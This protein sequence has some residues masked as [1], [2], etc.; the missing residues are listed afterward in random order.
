MNDKIIR[1]A[2]TV[3]G[4]MIGMIPAFLIANGQIAAAVILF[5]IYVNILLIIER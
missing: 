3:M 1:R 2:L 5:L 4:F